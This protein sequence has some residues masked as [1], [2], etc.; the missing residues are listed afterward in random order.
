M[1]HCGGVEQR[2]I[3]LCNR[4]LVAQ[5][6]RDEHTCVR[7]VCQRLAHA[8]ANAVAQLVDVINRAS[9]IRGETTIRLVAAHAAGGAQLVFQQPC[10]NI[11][12]VWV[13]VTVWPLE[14]HGE[15]PALACMQRWQRLALQFFDAR[16]VPTERDSRRHRGERRQHFFYGKRKAHALCVRLRQFV[17]DADQFNIATFPFA[18]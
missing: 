11:E 2:P 4:A 16:F 18:G 15:L 10:F 5:R 14:T 13:G 1:R 3:G 9:C 7:L 17:D 8:F 6:E 12:T